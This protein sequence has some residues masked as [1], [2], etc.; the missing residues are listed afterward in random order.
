MKVDSAMTRDVICIEA[1]DCLIDAQEIMREWEI[2]HLPVTQDG[3]LVG[4]LSDR[5]VLAHAIKTEAGEL[6]LPSIPIAEVMTRNPITCDVDAD[7]AS[8]GQTM[9][10]EKIDSLP[11]VDD[12]GDLVGLI[13]SSDLIQILVDRERMALGRPIPF[14][15]KLHRSVRRTGAGIH[16]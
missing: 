12:D 14:A 2:R 16:G 10:D 8:I 9:L 11:V 13:T 3:H 15:F 1:N 6:L 5:D 7:I 4:I